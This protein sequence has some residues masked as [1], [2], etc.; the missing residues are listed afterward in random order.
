VAAHPDHAGVK[1][2]EA[3]QPQPHVGARFELEMGRG[4]EANLNLSI[5][6]FAYLA[7]FA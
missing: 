3:G 6:Y 2:F 7:Y 5:A 1:A 4:P